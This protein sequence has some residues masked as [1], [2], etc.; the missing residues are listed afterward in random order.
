MKRS[1]LLLI[2]LV[3]LCFPVVYLCCAFVNWSVNPS[4]WTENNRL[5]CVTLSFWSIVAVVACPF[6]WSK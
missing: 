5:F 2:V 6:W 1:P 3:L 4:D